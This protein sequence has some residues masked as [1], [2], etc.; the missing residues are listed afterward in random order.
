MIGPRINAMGRLEH[1]IDSLRLL[2]THKLDQATQLAKLLA[3]TNKMRQDETKTAVDHAL[4]MIDENN[5]PT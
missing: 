2:C 3:D 5:L 4:G 1:A